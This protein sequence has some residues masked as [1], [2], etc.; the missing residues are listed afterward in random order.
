MTHSFESGHFSKA[1]EVQR[2]EGTGNWDF[3]RF[4]KK[5]GYPG[6]NEE[7]RNKIL[8]NSRAHGK[9]RGGIQKAGAETLSAIK[10]S[11]EEEVLAQVPSL[12][13]ATCESGKSFQFF[14]P[15]FLHLENRN[16]LVYSVPSLG[17]LLFQP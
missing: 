10:S 4:L 3:F 8:K 1:M 6:C 16:E 5:I 15:H 11:P 12:T 7:S 17:G 9:H 13:P 2:G 14:V